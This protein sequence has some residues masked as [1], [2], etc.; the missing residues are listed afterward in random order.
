MI[1][2]ETRAVIER[3]V[4]ALELIDDHIDRTSHCNDHAKV[5]AAIAEARNLLD[6]QPAGKDAWVDSV[7]KQVAELPDRNSPEGQPEM[8]LVTADELADILRS[9]T[10]AAPNGFVLVP[11]EPTHAIVSAM[12]CS[13]A[14]DDEGEFPLLMDLIDFSGENKNRAMMRVSSHS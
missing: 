5:S 6:A 2:A 9:H 12:L 11:V 7:I 8:M 1:D 4:E 10:A 14:R 13:K 3:L